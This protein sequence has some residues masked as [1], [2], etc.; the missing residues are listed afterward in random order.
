MPRPP[1]IVPRFD[2][3]SPAARRRRAEAVPG[4]AV[5]GRPEPRTARRS[6]KRRALVWALRWGFIASVWLTLAAA[7]VVLWFAHDLPRPEAALDAARRPS[8]TL[9]DRG[10]RVIA[11]YGDLV[12]EPLRL[13]DLPPALPAAVVA[14]EDRRF[15]HHS[16]VDVIGLLRAAGV[17]LVA[18][19]V[20][21]GGSTLTQQVA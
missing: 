13:R 20:V 1:P 21:Q 5:P 2:P 9:Q 16:G 17:N 14:V 15:W 18:G 7:V 3:P 8:L 12:G 4:R 6:W 11:A 19:H 10:G